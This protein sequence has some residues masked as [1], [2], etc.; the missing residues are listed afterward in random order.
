M[1]LR[2]PAEAVEELGIT[3]RQLRDGIRAGKYPAIEWGARH[4]VDL[5]VLGP[6]VQAEQEAAEAE[7]AL[8]TLKECAKR[9]G[10]PAGTLRKMTVLGIVP[11]R[12]TKKG[13][14][15]ELEAVEEALE[16]MMR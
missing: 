16:K 11:S 9:L 1:R 15:Y 2:T 12:R 7:R 5:D 14:R 6:I 10:I 13:Y 4:L 3:R 8:L